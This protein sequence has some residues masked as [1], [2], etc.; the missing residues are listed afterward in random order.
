MPPFLM[1]RHSNTY[2]D[3]VNQVVADQAGSDCDRKLGSGSRPKPML[4]IGRAAVHGVPPS[5]DETCC[6]CQHYEQGE[7]AGRSAE[8][9]FGRACRRGEYEHEQGERAPNA[10]PV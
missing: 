1:A 6:D 10:D 4:F 7:A 5:V 2:S 8:E 9:A 3:C